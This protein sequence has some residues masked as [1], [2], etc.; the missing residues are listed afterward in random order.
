VTGAVAV[1]VLVPLLGGT[2]PGGQT[3]QLAVFTV[4]AGTEVSALFL[5]SSSASCPSPASRPRPPWAVLFV[6]VRPSGAR[7]AGD[8]RRRAGRCRTLSGHLLGRPGT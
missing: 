5:G 1:V 2:A 7:R 4:P 6:L 8:R 3:F